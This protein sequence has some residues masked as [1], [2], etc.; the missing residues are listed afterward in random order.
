MGYDRLYFLKKAFAVYP[1]VVRPISAV[2]L[3]AHYARR[4]R[5]RGPLRAG[6]DAMVGLAFL[7]WI[8]WRARKVQR[9]FG[10]SEAWRRRAVQIA[11]ARFADPN[12][13]ALF[14]IDRAEALDGY[15]RRFED[16]ALNKIINPLG[17]GGRCLLADKLRF[18]ARCRATGLPQPEMVATL[19]A[20]RLAFDADPRGRDLVAKPA[21]GEG[22]DGVRILPAVG[23]RAALATLVGR[24]DSRSDWLIQARVIGHPALADVSLNALATIRVV[25]IL[26][27]AG[28]PE[29]VSATLRFASRAEAVVDNMKGGGLIAAVDLETGR[30]GP[31][32]RGYGGDSV[33]HHPVT[34]ASI[35]GRLV[36]D[37]PAIQALARRAHKTGFA[38]YALI[39]W[40]I[41]ATPAGP[42]LI[43]GNA[44]PG[45]LMPQRAAGRGLA[46]G[47]YG[48]LLAHHLFVAETS[49]D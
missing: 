15:I 44:K 7:A 3:A 10:L 48:E 30:L 24:L 22:G 28:A 4:R 45:V 41:A 27:E 1:G 8:P 5:R 13:L 11:R 35:E 39:G 49:R 16:A 20:G 40:D 18:E 43:E 6:L 29:V 38:E 34:G 42:V 33:T 36:P 32:R 2:V 17:W 47:R 19:A 26:D 12:D 46:Q 14:G 25:T 21:D 31:G 23:D 37:W 9:K